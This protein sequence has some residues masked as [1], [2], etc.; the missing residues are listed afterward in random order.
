[1]EVKVCPA[2]AMIVYL[3]DYV[4]GNILLP[5]GIFVTVKVTSLYGSQS[6]LCVTM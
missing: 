1:M 3:C 4:G 6:L 5:T 2:G